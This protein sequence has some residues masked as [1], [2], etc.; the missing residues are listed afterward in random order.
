MEIRIRELETRCE[1]LMTMVGGA[2]LKGE[3]RAAA[4]V[5]LTALKDSLRSIYEK[6]KTFDSQSKLTNAERESF[7]PAVHEAMTRLQVSTKS[8]PARGTWFKE[9]SACRADLER[10]R[11]QLSSAEQQL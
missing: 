6:Y 10:Y 1:E 4:Q 9:L 8:R 7:L 3:Q 11:R 5:K 2:D